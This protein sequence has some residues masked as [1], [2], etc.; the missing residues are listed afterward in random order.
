MKDWKIGEIDVESG[1][2]RIL[3]ST[4]DARAVVIKLEAGAS[5]DDHEV[6]ERAFV[7]VISGEVE[8]TPVG[9]DANT[10]QG[11][12]GG[13]GLLVEFDPRERHRVDA[14]TEARLLL[15][16]TPWPGRG[17]PGAMTIEEKAT[18]RERAAEA[19]QT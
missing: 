7:S 18:V 3:S 19:D 1:R 16:L 11:V 2:P 4:A 8:I 5:L 6:H 15:L 14:R 17:H 9:A 12:E 13:P 10:T